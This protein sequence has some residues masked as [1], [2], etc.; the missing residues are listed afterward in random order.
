MC[1]DD[2]D[3]P[4]LA[5][6]WGEGRGGCVCSAGHSEDEGTRMGSFQGLMNCWSSW[7]E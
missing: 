6:V 4:L 7:V 3:F 1:L 5:S 2:Y